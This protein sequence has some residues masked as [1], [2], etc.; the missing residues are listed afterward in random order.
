MDATQV[1]RRPDGSIDFDFYRARAVA[2]RA[3]TLRDAFRP[4]AMFR[5]TLIAIAGLTAFKRRECPELNLA[6]W[7]WHDKVEDQ[8]AAHTADELREAY[9]QP[10]FDEGKFLAGAAE[11]LE[12]VKAFWDGLENDRLGVAQ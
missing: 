7:T 5:F 6:F 2:L 9:F 3:Q 12:G 4:K 11:M 10:G 8:H 1:R